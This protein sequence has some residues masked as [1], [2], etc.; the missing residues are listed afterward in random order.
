V[1]KNRR[2]CR[3]GAESDGY[4]CHW[5]CGNKLAVIEKVYTVRRRGDRATAQPAAG[6][7]GSDVMLHHFFEAERRAFTR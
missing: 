7:K 6:R 3:M 2:A 1:T 5:A 4:F